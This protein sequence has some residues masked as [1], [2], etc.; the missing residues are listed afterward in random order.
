MR[1]FF[2]LNASITAS[3]AS[4]LDLQSYFEGLF[5]G[6]MN[7]KISI[8]VSFTLTRSVCLFIPTSEVR[9]RLGGKT[10]KSFFLASFVLF[11]F[12]VQG[13]LASKLTLV[14]ILKPS[15][16]QL[17]LAAQAVICESVTWESSAVR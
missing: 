3:C 12:L 5:L 6:G 11:L 15:H 13:P 1:P 14:S 8:G 17:S 16:R 2:P 9:S 10:E 4:S 7:E